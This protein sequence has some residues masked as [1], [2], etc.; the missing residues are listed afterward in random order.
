MYL[1]STFYQ[2]KDGKMTQDRKKPFEDPHGNQEIN[3]LGNHNSCHDQK[4]IEPEESEDVSRRDFFRKSAEIA[5]MALFGSVGIDIIVEKVTERVK[6]F[7]G[8]SK[9]AD[10]VGVNMQRSGLSK[11]AFAEESDLNCPE[12]WLF[13]DCPDPGQ[14]GPGPDDC[15]GTQWF[16]DCVKAGSD[17]TCDE[18][19]CGAESGKQII[20]V[21]GGV[22]DGKEG[23]FECND[24]FTCG[25]KGNDKIVDFICMGGG[26]KGNEVDFD[27]NG[28]FDSFECEA[29][30]VFLCEY[31]FDCEAS[32]FTC[33]ANP[34]GDAKCGVPGWGLYGEG[35]ADPGDFICK[36]ADKGG[37]AAGGFECDHTFVCKHEQEGQEFF[38][39]NDDENK[40]NTVFNCPG[41]FYCDMEGPNAWFGCTNGYTTG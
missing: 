8:I 7:D 18:Y 15:D 31:E 2:R 38:C 24:D 35:G 39:Y 3:D 22:A 21:C 28:L 19:N 30:H 40:N 23:G 26:Q 17:F 32:N 36:D 9:L 33:N 10:S 6:E 27:C 13:D 16:N 14:G 29:L 5:A 34:D 41:T 4:A 12:P 11:S 1:T 20:F 25:V 37:G